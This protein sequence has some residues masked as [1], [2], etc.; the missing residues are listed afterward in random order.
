MGTSSMIPPIQAKS[1]QTAKAA[2]HYVCLVLHD[3]I[4]GSVVEQEQAV[5]QAI[6]T[7]TGLSQLIV[8]R[9]ECYRLLARLAALGYN[10]D[11]D[12]R[13]AIKPMA[14]ALKKTFPVPPAK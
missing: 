12:L 7:A 8:A 6:E 9:D 3:A 10:S 11:D 4:Q 14:E 13:E 1:A 2:A 5:A